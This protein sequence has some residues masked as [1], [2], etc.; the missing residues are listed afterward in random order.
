MN[1]GRLGNDRGIGPNNRT[2]LPTSFPLRMKLIQKT[3]F[4]VDTGEAH[5]LAEGRLRPEQSMA[6]NLFSDIRASLSS[7]VAQ[8]TPVRL[9]HHR[10]RGGTAVPIVMTSGSRSWGILPAPV[11]TNLNSL[12]GQSRSFMKLKG[13]VGLLGVRSAGDGPI[14][15]NATLWEIPAA[16]VG[17]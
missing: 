7:R 9:T 2:S 3:I 1:E 10:T 16:F 4:F 5:F 11:S 12:V 6:Q 15:R 8:E 14:Q 13:A 17:M